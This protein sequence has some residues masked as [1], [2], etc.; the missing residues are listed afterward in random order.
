MAEEGAK[1]N[2]EVKDSLFTFTKL[3]RKESDD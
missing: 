1:P 3:I 2:E